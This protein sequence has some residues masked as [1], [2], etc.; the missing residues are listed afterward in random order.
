[1]FGL[2]ACG[3]PVAFE[4]ERTMLV[5]GAPPVVVRPPIPVPEPDPPP[6]APPSRVEV[7]DNRIEI[8]E[9]IQFEQNKATIVSV[10]FDLLDEVAAV[11]LKHSF[12]KKIRIEGHASAD[13]IAA[14]NRKLSDDRAR[15]VMRY[16][17]KQG[18]PKEQLVARGYGSDKPIAD[19]RTAV[20]RE[21]NRRVEFNII[22]QDVTLRRVEGA[23]APK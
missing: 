23:A 13:G 16:L 10:S 11:I 14:Y 6:P 18:V 12:I 3:K 8:S 2:V 22:A 15:S 9:K 1:M 21:K 17:V 4:G 5:A 7:R 19:N 20:G